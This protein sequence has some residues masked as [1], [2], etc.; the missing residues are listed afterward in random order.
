M[1][2]YHNALLTQ[3][4]GKNTVKFDKFHFQFEVPFTIYADFESFLVK[5]TDQSDTH[6]PSGFCVLIGSIFEEYNYNLYCYSG[7]NVDEF[8]D[9]MKL[10][11]KRI[12]Q[13]LNRNVTIN[14]LTLE[15]L[16]KHDNARNCMT[17]DKQFTAQN[18]MAHHHCHVTGNYLGAACQ[19]CNLHLKFRNSNKQC[20]IAYFLHNSSAYDSHLII[21]KFHNKQANITVIPNNTEKVIGFQIDGIRYLDN[22]KFLPASLNDS[23]KI[24]YSAR[25]ARIASAVL[26]TALPSVRLSVCPSVCLS[27][28]L[29]VCHTP[30]LCQND[31]T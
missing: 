31:G 4:P 11:E 21:N 30:V 7:E 2:S 28:C 20:F 14:K 22:F 9:Y 27:V 3:N 25:N 29:S 23:V 19:A 13:I 17:C 8:F 5:I 15:Q 24:F 10:E 18:P 1:L 6:V 16:L 26:A 12:S